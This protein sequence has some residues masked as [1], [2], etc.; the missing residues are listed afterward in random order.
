MNDERPSE[1]PA[2]AE[3]QRDRLPQIVSAIEA[4]VRTADPVELLSHL[5]ILY[6]THAAGAD[7]DRDDKARWQAK[8]EW[9]A[10]LTFARETPTPERPALIDGQLLGQLEPL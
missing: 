8:I 3:R 7:N 5:T 1:L 10:W 9:L 6:Q 4:V 2:F